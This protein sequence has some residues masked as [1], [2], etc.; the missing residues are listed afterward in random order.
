MNNLKKEIVVNS[1]SL[2]E[3]LST[4]GV[5]RFNTKED[6]ILLSF[7]DDILKQNCY[8]DFIDE[9]NIMDIEKF[10]NHILHSN[11]QLRYCRIKLDDYK[12]LGGKQNID[13]YKLIKGRTN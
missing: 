12:N 6:I 8:Y 7:M 2:Y 9:C 1:L 5:D 3:Y 4:Y 11:P 10:I 13:T